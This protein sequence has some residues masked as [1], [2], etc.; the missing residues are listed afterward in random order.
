MTITIEQECVSDL[1][2]D[3]AT[4]TSNSPI[5]IEDDIELAIGAIEDDK[6][7]EPRFGALMSFGPLPIKEGSATRN[8]IITSAY[9]EGHASRTI[10][11][12][13]DTTAH[14][15]SCPLR[16]GLWDGK[17]AE[18]PAGTEAS[19]LVQGYAYEA[20]VSMRV[21]TAAS[22]GIILDTGIPTTN[23]SSND[24][25]AIMGGD[26]TLTPEWLQSSN[27]PSPW[28]GEEGSL[29]I[30]FNAQSSND[31][32]E[33]E[34]YMHFVNTSGHDYS[35]ATGDGEFL[36]LSLFNSGGVNISVRSIGSSVG[37][38][39]GVFID[40]LPTARD[41]IVT[42]TAFGSA[43]ALTSGNS[44]TWRLTLNNGDKGT[45]VR[46]LEVG[47]RITF[48]GRIAAIQ[49]AADA[50]SRISRGWSSELARGYLGPPNYF[51]GGGCPASWRS[52]TADTNVNSYKMRQRVNGTS[53]QNMVIDTAY[54]W[55]NSTYSPDF[56][57]D[58][59]DL[60][61]NEVDLATWELDDFMMFD[62]ITYGIDASLGDQI[63]YIH[64]KENTTSSPHL[65]GP[66]LHIDLEVEELVKAELSGTS[67]VEAAA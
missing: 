51:H 54:K 34:L 19:N 25:V 26:D 1:S 18:S 22:P 11:A 59:A 52:D 47:D 48:E 2:L 31:A 21:G 64:S 5:D 29:L 44:Y 56:T 50:N 43:P 38:F 66:T 27:D 42:F 58:I 20:M 65:P 49:F 61:Q 6:N 63:Q 10:T 33:L 41:G 30:H 12:P 24:R 23:D 55:G 40:D 39:N 57:L 62:L 7:P 13:D 37:T 46:A 60:I 45:G 15:I 16:D 8:V 67:S 4:A 3:P 9:I 14:R 28:Q 53:M 17:H 32:E 36:T 35:V